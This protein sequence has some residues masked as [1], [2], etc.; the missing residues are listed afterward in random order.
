LCSICSRPPVRPE[1]VTVACECVARAPAWRQRRPLPQTPCVHCCRGGSCPRQRR[2]LGRRPQRRCPRACSSQA[3]ST[4]RAP[5]P[6]PRTRARAALCRRRLP[7]PR[8]PLSS[9]PTAA[10]LGAHWSFGLLR[11]RLCWRTSRCPIPSPP[12]RPRTVR[13]R[14][15]PQ[16]L[17]AGGPAALLTRRARHLGARRSRDL[18]LLTKLFG[19]RRC[20]GRRELWRTTPRRPWPGSSRSRPSS[21][22]SCAA[23]D[24]LVPRRR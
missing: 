5:S 6:L 3:F 21:A 10:T 13:C 8:P 15:R 12:P 1:L 16:V 7:R 20:G 2:Q 9:A 18:M 11:R 23:V 24:R 22:S 4:A 19:R 14:P 17:R